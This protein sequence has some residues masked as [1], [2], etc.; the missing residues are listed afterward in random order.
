[1][2]QQYILAKYVEKKFVPTCTLS[3][4]KLDL[5]LAQ[6][7]ADGNFL[8]ASKMLVFGANVNMIYKRG[9]LLHYCTQRG[10]AAGVEFLLQRDCQPNLLDEDECT[11][12]D[13]AIML[14]E[15]EC[16]KLLSS[17]GAEVNI[18]EDKNFVPFSPRVGLTR[19]DSSCGTSQRRSSITWQEDLEPQAQAQTHMRAHRRSSNPVKNSSKP[20]PRLKKSVL[21]SPLIDSSVFQ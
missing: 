11:P 14:E 16:I 20:K 10:D 8:E 15:E 18:V 5:A 7:L 17:R 13:K 21:S 1:V 19:S 6:S 9:T 12:L 4:A 3:Q 2:K